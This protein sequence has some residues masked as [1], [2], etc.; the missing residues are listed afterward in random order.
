MSGFGPQK[1]WPA[2][3]SACAALNLPARGHILG[4]PEKCRLDSM[5]RFVFRLLS[6]FALSVAVIM[7]VLDSTR[8]IAVS[9]PVMTP[10]VQ[11]W[12]AV[13]PETIL[14]ARQF[15]DARLSPMIWQLV[16]EP[17]LALPGFAVFLGLALLFH[18]IGRRPQRAARRLAV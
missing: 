10:L 1:P 11:S 4:K 2:L 7:I 6:L 5:I 12:Q 8:S 18:A 14:A 15:S 17:I 9:A 16:V 3:N 13:S